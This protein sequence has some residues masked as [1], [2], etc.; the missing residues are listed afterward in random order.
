MPLLP[1]HHEKGMRVA[2]M[3][4]WAII[5][6]GVVAPLMMTPFIVAA[7][8]VATVIMPARATLDDDTAVAEFGG[9]ALGRGGYRHRHA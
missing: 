8:I 4:S 5:A 7:I 6:S 2:L 3:V 9:K 1:L